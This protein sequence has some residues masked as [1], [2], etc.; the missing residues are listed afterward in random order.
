[1]FAF[2]ELT[3]LGKEDQKSVRKLGYI[4]LVMGDQEKIRKTIRKI[5]MMLRPLGSKRQ[6][7]NFLR[8]KNLHV[9]K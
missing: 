4:I 9:S 8:S 6:V 1:M 5:A 3:S 2:K 7:R